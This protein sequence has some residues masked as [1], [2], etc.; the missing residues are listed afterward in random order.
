MLGRNKRGRVVTAFCSSFVLISAACSSNPAPQQPSIEQLAAKY[1][2]QSADKATGGSVSTIRP[3]EVNAV[4]YRSVVEMIEAR[5]PGL[6]VLRRA[7]M[8]YTI[9]IRG[10]GEPLIVIDG[11]PSADVPVA[12]TLNALNP[13]DVAKI[14]VLKDGASG[15]IYGIRGADGVILITTKRR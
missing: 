12:L 8:D 4:T 5:V 14:E 7:G 9:S 2:T 3:N 13:N 11:M 1:A 6:R 10:G 15:A